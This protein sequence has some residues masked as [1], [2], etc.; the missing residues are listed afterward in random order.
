MLTL[1]HTAEVHVARFAA[2]RD[3]LAPGAELRQEVRPDWLA[4]ARAEGVAAVAEEVTAFIRAAGGPVICTCTTLGPVAE[5]AGA[6]RV[7]R[8]MMQR[9]ARFGGPVLLVYT[10]ASTAEASAALLCEYTPDIRRLDLSPL[11]PLFETGRGADFAA[12][13]AE[14]VRSELTRQPAA[15]VVLAQVSMS[16][17]SPLLAGCGVPVLSAPEA[18]L[19]AGL[20]L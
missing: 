5:A 11:W 6:A 4:R 18:A 7:D 2:L 12:A 16:D 15:V 13:I 17:A 1:L 8:P 19:R 14:G 3:R 20:G 9:A 10:L